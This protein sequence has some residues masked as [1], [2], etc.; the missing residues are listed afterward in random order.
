MKIPSTQLCIFVVPPGMPCVAFC[1]AGTSTIVENPLQISS[2]MQNKANF[3][4]DQMN[5]SAIT[6]KDYKN[7]T[8]SG[9]G[10][11]EP[12][13]NPIQ[14][15]TNP[16]TEKPKMNVSTNITK[17][18]DNKSHFWAIAKQTQYK[19]NL[20]CVA[21]GEAGTKPISKQNIDD[22]S[23]ILYTGLLYKKKLNMEKK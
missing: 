17:G 12:K 9:S 15:Q 23:F 11:N 22:Y 13:T 6:T 19:P 21:S 16:I 7:K 18:Y 2:F 1:E 4:D 14:T 10:K 20:S 5:V 3:P 8:L